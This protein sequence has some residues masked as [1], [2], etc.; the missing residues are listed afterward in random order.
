MEHLREIILNLVQQIRGKCC[1]NA[2]LFLA[3][4]AILFGGGESFG[5][6]VEG[7]LRNICVKSF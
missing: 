7:P 2:V 6:L 4:V 3:L 5:H 1:L